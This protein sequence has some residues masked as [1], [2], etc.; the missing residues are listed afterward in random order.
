MAVNST[1]NRPSHCEKQPDTRKPRRAK[2]IK[3]CVDSP[4]PTAISHQQQYVP[5]QL[6]ISTLT[7]VYQAYSSKVLQ[8]GLAQFVITVGLGYQQLDQLCLKDRQETNQ[9]EEI[10]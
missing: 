9:R 1:R 3:T 5:L 6:S 7:R 8:L 10:K 4:F 2:G